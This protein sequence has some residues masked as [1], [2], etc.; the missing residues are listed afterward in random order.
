LSGIAYPVFAH[1][2]WTPGGWLVVEGYLD[3]GGA[4]SIHVIGGSA[5]LALVWMLGG[6]HGKYSESGLPAAV[7]GH[8]AVLVLSGAFA[9]LLGWLGLNCAG[10][11]LYSRT[12]LAHLVPVVLNTILCAAGGALASAVLTKSRYGRPDASL[13]AN[14]WTAG[15]VA[16]SAAA[17][18]VHPMAAPLIG[19]VAG[20]MVPFAIEMADVRLAFDDPGG[21]VAVHFLGGLWGLIAAG[22][23]GAGSWIAQIAGVATLIGLLFPMVFG[24]VGMTSRVIPLRTT[25]EGDRQGMDLHEL[26]AGAYPEFMTHHED[27]WGR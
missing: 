1:W 7:P 26:G 3:T 20:V 16:S 6:R 11:I 10:A 13:C 23:F 4:G 18:F 22:L 19:I 14:G 24:F 27:T 2:S 25:A 9:A 15:L 8:D 21:T 17:A 12:P 5:A